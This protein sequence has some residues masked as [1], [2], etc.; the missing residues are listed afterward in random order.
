MKR[1]DFIR[2]TGMM[3]LGSLIVPQMPAFGRSIDPAEALQGVDAALKRELADVAL[4]AAK[5]KGATYA[6]VRIGRYLRQFVA[7]RDKKVQGVSN[8][9]NYGIGIRVLANGSWGF[10]A[11]HVVTKDAI[12]KAAE[13][14]VAVAKANAKIQGEPV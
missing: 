3:G 11:T 6:D 2:Y 5:S 9:E 14:A 7:T 12:A 10:A 8:T 4:N 13:Q 1:K